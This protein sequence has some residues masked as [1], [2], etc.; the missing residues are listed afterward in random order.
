[1]NIE[2]STDA[3]RNL[4]SILLA[5][6]GLLLLIFNGWLAERV[7][8]GY[9]KSGLPDWDEPAWWGRFVAIF[10][11]LMLIALAVLW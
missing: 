7:D 8:E 2:S 6:F 1:M 10:T 3:M 5:V 11:G 9:K 4:P